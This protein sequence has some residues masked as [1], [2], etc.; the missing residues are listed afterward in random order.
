MTQ[1]AEFTKLIGQFNK[2][3]QSI[4]TVWAT[5]KS[6]DWDQ[7]ICICTGLLDDLDYYEVLLGIGDVYIKPKKGTQVLLGLINGNHANAFV[8][9]AEAIEEIQTNASQTKVRITEKGVSIAKGTESLKT[10]LND[11]IDELNKI[12][13]LQGTTINVAAMNVIKQRLNGVLIE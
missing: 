1:V 3:R 11:M 7:K 6:I 12:V 8:L 2:E 13:V 4:A 10:V 9:H 5:I